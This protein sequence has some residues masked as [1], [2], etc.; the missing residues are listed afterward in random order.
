MF[1]SP[2][3]DKSQSSALKGKKHTPSIWILGREHKRN[4]TI[5]W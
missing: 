2:D 3:V 4:H 5:N 1:S